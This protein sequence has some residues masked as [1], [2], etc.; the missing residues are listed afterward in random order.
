MVVISLAIA[1]DF[2]ATRGRVAAG[3]N[4]R[5]SSQPHKPSRH[6]AN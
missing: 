6:V 4:D 5:D 2:H 3:E 1:A